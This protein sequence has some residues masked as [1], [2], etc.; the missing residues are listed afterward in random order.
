MAAAQEAAT[1]LW[2]VGLDSLPHAT[3]VPV[4]LRSNQRIKNLVARQVGWYRLT[5]SQSRS[6]LTKLDELLELIDDELGS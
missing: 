1:S 4:R 6:V 3:G 5:G 2:L